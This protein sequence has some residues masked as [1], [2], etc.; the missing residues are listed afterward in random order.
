MIKDTTFGKDSALLGWVHYGE[1]LMC[2]K[3]TCGWSVTK[4]DYDIKAWVHYGEYV[5]VE[6]EV[7]TLLR[8]LNYTIQ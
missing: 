4:L 2:S 8:N 6:N 7:T 3:I 1:Y 5:I